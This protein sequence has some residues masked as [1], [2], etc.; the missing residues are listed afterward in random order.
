MKAATLLASWL[1]GWAAL[2]TGSP[3]TPGYL[4]IRLSK[5]PTLMDRI[6]DWEIHS[7]FVD[8]DTERRMTGEEGL[9]YHVILTRMTDPASNWESARQVLES[10]ALDGENYQLVF[11]I[12]RVERRP[13]HQRNTAPTLAFTIAAYPMAQRSD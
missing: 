3:G 5:P 4:E 2:A 11:V 12:R 9:V 10:L 6:R 7:P 1:L 13:V 8:V